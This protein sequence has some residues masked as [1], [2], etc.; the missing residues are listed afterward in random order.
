MRYILYFFTLGLVFTAGMLVGN[1]YLP[2][3]NA[4]VAA[5]VSVPDLNRL[6]PA[7]DEATVLQAQENLRVLTQALTSCPVVVEAEK[8]RLFNQ[9]SL[10][11][12]LQDFE[13]KKSTYEAEIA[14]NMESGRTTS[15]F[16]RA[17][18][19]YSSAKIRTERL[20]DELFPPALPQ[21]TPADETAQASSSTITA[22]PQTVTQAANADGAQQA[23]PAPKAQTQT[24]DGKKADK[25]APAAK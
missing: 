22:S 24:A 7:L 17:A 20:A 1:F 25:K 15:Q 23:A 14:K 2:A 10:F 8:E 5:A 16:S 6:N 9:I 18:A 13:V 21:E 12:A 3:R 19:D 11:L 4:S